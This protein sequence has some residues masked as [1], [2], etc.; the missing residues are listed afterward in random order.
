MWCLGPGAPAAEGG[1]ES[2][3]P[4]S[5]PLQHHLSTESSSLVP[6]ASPLL[7]PPDRSW[8]A[9]RVT[10]VQSRR[11]RRNRASEGSS[12][13]GEA[14]CPLAP[15]CHSALCLSLLIRADKRSPVVCTTAL[16]PHLTDRKTDETLARLTLSQERTPLH[17]LS[18]RFEAQTCHLATGQRASR[19]GRGEGGEG[20]E[21]EAEGRGLRESRGLS[22][23]R[24]ECLLAF[25]SPP[26]SSRPLLQP[27]GPPVH[28]DAHGRLWP[29]SPPGAGTGMGRAACRQCPCRADD[30]LGCLGMIQGHPRRSQRRHQLLKSDRGFEELLL[31]FYTFISLHFQQA[32]TAHLQNHLGKQ[33][34]GNFH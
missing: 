25:L 23:D 18:D 11:W 21:G 4:L 33:K 8:N 22:Q 16:C 7:S 28:P 3:A 9:L 17:L 12:E 27:C 2:P 34:N 26:G 10:A 31:Y 30:L 24:A 14:A 13:S 19:E 15:S 1:A 29:G 32:G 20:D 5:A 6:K